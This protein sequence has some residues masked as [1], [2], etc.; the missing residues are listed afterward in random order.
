MSFTS[1]NVKQR[2]VCMRRV[3]R[4]K[5][6]L[7]KFHDYISDLLVA[8][9]KIENDFTNEDKAR[10]GIKKMQKEIKELNIIA[11]P[12]TRTRKKK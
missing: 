11:K 4:F 5:M 7:V 9:D 3:D 12:K 2:R 6:R 1:Y 10:V 8:I